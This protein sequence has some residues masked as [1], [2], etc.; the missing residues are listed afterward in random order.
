MD[1]K[2]LEEKQKQRFLF[3]Q[4]IHDK[5]DGDETYPFE[6]EEVGKEL[7]FDVSTAE[8]I[9]QY[10]VG[11]N[12]LKEWGR[13]TSSITHWGVVEMEEKIAHPDKPTEHFPI[14]VTLIIQNGGVNIVSNG[15]IKNEGKIV[16]RDSAES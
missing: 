4:Y 11:E 14:N 8:K 6:T 1:A 12:L 9:V 16:G 2:Q 5:S 15:D 10:L 7:G 13:G 3:L